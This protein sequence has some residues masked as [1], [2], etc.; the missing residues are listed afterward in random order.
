MDINTQ[1]AIK[2]SIKT[3]KHGGSL[4]KLGLNHVVGAFTIWGAGLLLSIIAFIIELFTAQRIKIALV[5][6]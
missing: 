4:V 3:T 2:E 5:Q 6:H 1:K